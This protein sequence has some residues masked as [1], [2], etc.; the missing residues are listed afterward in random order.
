M[1]A[2]AS[3]AGSSARPALHLSDTS[4]PV[5]RGTGFKAGEQ[6]KNTFIGGMH[7]VRKKTAS[8]RGTF[9]VQFPGADVNRCLGFAVTAVGNRGSRATFKR[10]HGQCPLP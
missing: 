4:A 8:M 9:V 1:G 7:A 10:A 6:V 2:S 3:P 5:F